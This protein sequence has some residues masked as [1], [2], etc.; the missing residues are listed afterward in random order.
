MSGTMLLD[1]TQRRKHFQSLAEGHSRS[2]TLREDEYVRVMPGECDTIIRKTLEELFI[3]RDCCGS[4]LHKQLLLSRW[5]RAHL[6]C[7]Y[8]PT[9]HR[10][11]S[12]SS[13]GARD[14]RGKIPASPRLWGAGR[15]SAM[16]WL[17]AFQRWQ[18][19]ARLS[20]S[21]SQIRSRTCH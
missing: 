2:C 20:S 11:S 7:P 5:V 3:S 19:C 10:Q 15:H 16:N 6:G 9:S 8:K 21:L 4:N 18:A 12:A 14:G 1:L 17:A 13:L